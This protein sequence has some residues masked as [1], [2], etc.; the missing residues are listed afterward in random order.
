MG[1]RDFIAAFGVSMLGCVVMWP[2]L[3]RAQRPGRTARLGTLLYG[4]PQSD[5]TLG[6]VR[7]GLR[8]LGYVEGQE[9]PH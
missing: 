1:R 9:S 3:A 5:T 2:P 8:E 6:P 4:N 7:R